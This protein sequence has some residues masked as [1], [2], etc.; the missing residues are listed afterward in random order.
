MRVKSCCAHDGSTPRWETLFF[1]FFQNMR[2]H[3]WVITIVFSLYTLALVWCGDSQPFAGYQRPF[4]RCEEARAFA[5]RNSA[6]EYSV[7]RER[8][9]ARG[10]NLAGAEFNPDK[11]PGV[12]GRDYIYPQEQQFDYYKSRGFDVVR[13][14]FRWERL[15]PGLFGDFSPIELGRIRRVVATAR[16]RNM[17]VIVSPHNYGRYSINGKYALVGSR[18]V[19]IDAFV[20][21]WHRLAEHFVGEDAIYAFGLMNEPHDTDG[22]WKSAA[23]AGLDAIRRTDRKRLV[24]A[25]GD[26]WSGAW[27]WRTFNNDFLLDDSAGNLMY[28]AHQYFDANH[29]GTYR[30]DY[31]LSGAYPNLGVDLVRPFVGWLREHQVAGIITEFGV[32]NHDPRWLDVVDRLL[33]WLARENISWVYWAGGPWWNE[34]PLSAE[35]RDG[36]DAPVMSILSKGYHAQ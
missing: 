11:I 20:D 21:F 9:F 6:A 14:P 29:S 27:S 16:E 36:R 3:T 35:P 26:Q 13:L 32:P 30:E 17:K 19:P 7:A 5:L 1:T 12:Y 25:P 15:Q 31:G 18:R 28:E 8:G 23:Q 2:C 4:A 22:F 24:L 10:I 34:Y 33:A